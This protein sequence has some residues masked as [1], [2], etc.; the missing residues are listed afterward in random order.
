ME[1]NCLFGKK[2]FIVGGSGG[3][4][5]EISLLLATKCKKIVVHGSKKSEQ[6]DFLEKKIKES[7]D[8]QKIVFDFYESDF[9]SIKSSP[10][11]SEA[12]NCDILCVCFGPFIQKRLEETTIQDWQK[13]ALFDYALPGVLLS[14]ALPKMIEQKFGRILFFGG[15]GT[16][17]RSEFRTNVA[18]AG[19]KSALNVLVESTAANYS[20]YGITCN[21]IL[22]GFTQTQYTSKID[23]ILSAK[24]PLGRQINAKTIAKTALFLLENEDINGALLRLD[25]G[26][27]A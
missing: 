10:V 17:H 2:A 8:F 16:S 1:E 3:I 6:F 22:P 15:T 4:G 13:V 24:M 20:K 12:A 21:A 23:E 5:R 27:S 18:Y 25:Q 7:A 14:L 9:L 19:A 11:A 26:W